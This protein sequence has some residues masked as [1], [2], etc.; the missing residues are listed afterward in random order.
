MAVATSTLLIFFACTAAAGAAGAWLVTRSMRMLGTRTTPLRGIGWALFLLATAA[1]GALAL[2]HLSGRFGAAQL[3]FRAPTFYLSAAALIAAAIWWFAQPTPRLLRVGLPSV[4]AGCLALGLVALRLHGTA[5]PIAMLMP[6]MN[7]AA[8]ELTWYDTSG[9]VRSLAELEGKVVLVNF[10]ATW[11][12]PCR[13][14]MPLLSRMQRE[15]GERGFVVLYLSLEEAEVLDRFLSANHFDGTH[16]RLQRAADF[17]DAGKYYPLSY[18]IGR[19][20]QVEERWS[21]RPNEKW[22]DAAIRASL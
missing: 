8:P 6:T 12:A 22:L 16:G 1:M 14:E 9:Q 13:K 4:V 21:G 18:L 2:A 19:Q 17:Y 7:A 20:G 10:W 15:H 3:W 5:T 11:C